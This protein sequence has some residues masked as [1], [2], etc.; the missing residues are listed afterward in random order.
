MKIFEDNELLSPIYQKAIALTIGKE[1]VEREHNATSVIAKQNSEQENRR[2]ELLAV[3]EQANKD[4][5]I[6]EHGKNHFKHQMMS[7]FFTQVN[8]QVNSAFDQKESL[9]TNLLQIEDAAPAIME[10]L[11]VKAA[12][13]KRI[14]PLVAS[15]PW[16]ADELIKLVNKPQYRKRADVQVS[17][18]N[19]ALTYIGLE[20][21]KLVMPTFMLKHWLPT[22][23]SPFGA[24]KR[25]L[26]ND[27]LTIALATQ[28]LAK[29]H[30]LD[31]FTAF[32][33]AMFSNIGLLAVTRSYIQTYNDLHKEEVKK[34]FD[35]KDKRLHDVLVEFDLSPELMH[36]QLTTRSAAVSADLVELM[37]FDR[38]MIT[39]PIFD[40]A[41]T[42]NLQ[43]MTP[44]A[45]LIVKAK[46]YVMYR[47]LAADEMLST[48][49]AKT[50][51]SSVKLTKAEIALLKKSD[52]DHIK[53]TFD[54]T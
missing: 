46:A 24:M 14:S 43:T 49:Q 51:L 23:T 20:N 11:A 54:H 7:K 30:K 10:I 4:R 37:R 1:Y 26:W 35:N 48:E 15:L 5:L 33:A 22:S 47:N 25:K 45:Q 50:L 13:V 34:A 28:A 21:L 44:I 6:E 42:N 52:I 8:T 17:D 36:Q 53:L 40:L 38:L 31:T 2:R 3:E 39:E 9:Y 32:S 27:S 18:A 16:L 12:S 19:L 41:Y 29:L